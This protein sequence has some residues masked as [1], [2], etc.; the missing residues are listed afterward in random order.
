[1][2]KV[3]IVGPLGVGKTSFISRLEQELKNIGTTIVFGEPSMTEPTINKILVK[4]Y[5]DTKTWAYPLEVAIASAHEAMYEEINKIEQDKKIDYVLIDTPSSAFIYSRIFFKNGLFDQFEL[6]V[7]DSIF[8]KFNFDFIIVIEETAEETIR[9]ILLRH[10][11]MEISNFDYI[12]QHVQDYQEFV[13]V[14]LKERF[15]EAEVIYLKDLPELESND[16]K[17]LLEEVIKKLKAREE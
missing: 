12:R 6:A 15:P 9:R 16:Y 14:Y 17:E 1:M 13:G 10:R 7:V 11:N 5:A 3:G 8:R 2:L 4:F